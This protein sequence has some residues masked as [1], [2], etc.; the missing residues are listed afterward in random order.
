[1]ALAHHLA[2]RVSYIIFELYKYDEKDESSKCKQHTSG[3]RPEETLRAEHLL[4]DDVIFGPSLKQHDHLL[5]DSLS[6]R[7]GILNVSAI[8]Q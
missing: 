7:V 8:R 4:V 5:H 6:Q 1:M 3:K 2:R